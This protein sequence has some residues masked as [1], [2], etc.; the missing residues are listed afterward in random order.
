MGKDA[1]EEFTFKTED[2]KIICDKCPDGDIYDS[3]SCSVKCEFTDEGGKKFHLI[4]YASAGK[5]WD[6][7]IAAWLPIPK[8]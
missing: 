4:D 6:T 2:G 8:K 1:N 3:R 5:D 7:D